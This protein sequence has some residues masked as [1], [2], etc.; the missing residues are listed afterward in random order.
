MVKFAI[1][2]LYLCMTC[3]CIAC[4]GHLQNDLYL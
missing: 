2:L 3:L 1:P 4:K